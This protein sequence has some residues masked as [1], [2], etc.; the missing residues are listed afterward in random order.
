MLKEIKYVGSSK[1]EIYDAYLEAKTELAE[2]KSKEPVSTVEKAKKDARG[3][4]AYSEAKFR[5]NLDSLEDL[6]IELARV[7][8]L[9]EKSDRKRYKE[10]SKALKKKIKALKKELRRD[11]RNS[12]EAREHLYAFMESSGDLEAKKELA[13]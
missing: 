10:E 3:E 13:R 6:V 1:K 9:Y 2:L 5:S 8:E 7:K 4:Y 11:I 12:K